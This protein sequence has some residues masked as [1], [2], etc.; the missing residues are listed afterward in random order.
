MELQKIEKSGHMPGFFYLLFF[1]LYLRFDFLNAFRYFL[2]LGV[3]T[4]K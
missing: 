2:W 4:K 3:R 1:C